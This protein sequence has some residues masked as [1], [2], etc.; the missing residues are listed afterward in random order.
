MKPESPDFSGQRGFPGGSEGEE[1]AC[2]TG[3]SSL[4]PGSGRSPGERKDYAL[5]YSYWENS[6][7]RGAWWE[8]VHRVAKS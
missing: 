4:I 6:R 8:S 7:D 3:D 2:N 5:Q 1:S